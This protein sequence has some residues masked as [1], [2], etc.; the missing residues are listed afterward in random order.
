MELFESEF[1]TGDL[2]QLAHESGPDTTAAEIGVGLEVVD[3]APVLDESVGITVKDDP[4][5]KAVIE[6][7][8]DESAVLRVETAK[9]LVRDWRDVVVLDGR[10]RES[11]SAA[12][13]GD[14]DP[15]VDQLAP[16]FGGDLACVGDLDEV[17]YF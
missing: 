16:E 17:G 4:S 13:V 5:G 9:E 7:G 6:S 8:G 2:P 1:V 14:R 11:G 12:R 3:R 15:A 10:E